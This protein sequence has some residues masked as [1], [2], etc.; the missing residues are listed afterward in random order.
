MCSTDVDTVTKNF[1]GCT[2]PGASVCNGN[3]LGKVAFSRDFIF[4]VKS[5]NALSQY[6]YPLMQSGMGVL[7]SKRSISTQKVSVVDGVSTDF[8]RKDMK[9]L[10]LNI[11][12]R[13]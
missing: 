3:L 11:C 7:S 4:G 1:S 8:C 9:T 6:S 2:N 5:R 12:A 13:L 10:V